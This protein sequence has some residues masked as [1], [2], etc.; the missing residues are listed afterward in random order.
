MT[1]YPDRKR[2]RWTDSP[3]NAEKRQRV[4]DIPLT[5]AQPPPLPV[6]SSN[7]ARSE[8]NLESIAALL[9]LRGNRENPPPPHPQ[10][11]APQIA[12]LKALY[13]TVLHHQSLLNHLYR[14]SVLYP[15]NA[16]ALQQQQDRL[17]LANLAVA[18]F[19]A[20]LGNC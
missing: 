19:I 12:I 10:S 17:T 15:F 4:A 13:E 11:Y 1:P 14:Q 2:I 18:R 8:K 16:L 5:G 7:N 3:I 9:G 6:S 20:G